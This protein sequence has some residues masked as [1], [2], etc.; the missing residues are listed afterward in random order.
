MNVHPFICLYGE[1]TKIRDTNNKKTEKVINHP[2][3]VSLP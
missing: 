2:A 3:T 1:K